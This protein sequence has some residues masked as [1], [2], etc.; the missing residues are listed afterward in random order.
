MMIES[1]D[2]YR[3]LTPRTLAELGNLLVDPVPDGALCWVTDEESPWYLAKGSL[4]ALSASIIATGRGVGARGRWIKFSPGGAGGS[5]VLSET[6]TG[7][8]SVEVLGP[9]P[10]FEA[11]S[12]D[13]DLTLATGFTFLTVLLTVN[14]SSNSGFAVGLRVTYSLD[15]AIWTPL[16]GA[17][18]LDTDSI[19]SRAHL[20]VMGTIEE[21]D[22]IRVRG[23]WTAYGDSGTWTIPADENGS[24]TITAWQA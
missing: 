24:A 11:M 1:A 2:A 21:P 7:P 13:L 19:V 8:I 22:A 23:E 16:P 20:S 14:S 9:A 5:S 6:L 17:S 18:L 3:L 10:A 4:A 12:A 15:G